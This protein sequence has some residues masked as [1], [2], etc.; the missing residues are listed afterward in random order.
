MTNKAT[1]SVHAGTRQDTVSGGVNTPLIASS[2]H[3]YL[4]Q[5]EVRYPRYFNTFNQQVVVE[6]LCALEQAEDGL[7]MSSGM[8]A[9]SLL[10]VGTLQHGDHAVFVEGIYGGTQDW[11]IGEL[12]A[13]GIEFDFVPLDSNAIDAACTDRTRLIYV[14]SPTNPLIDVLDLAA[15]AGIAQARGILSAIDNTFA[16]PILQNPI[17]LGIDC[18]IHSGTKYLGGHSD[19]C[20]GAILGSQELIRSLRPKAYR[21]G[22]SINAQ[23]AALLERSLKTL[24]LRVQRQS[25]NALH[26]AQA[27][28]TMD[29]VDQVYYPGLTHHPGHRIAAR[30]MSGFGGML[31]FR[32][33]PDIDP[34]ACLRRLEIIAPAVSLGGVETTICQPVQTSH[35]KISRQECERLGITPQLLRLSVGIE[36]AED[37][38]I[39]LRRAIRAQ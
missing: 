23:C 33:A 30:Q 26:I 15:V 2:A 31:S 4:N 37:L 5:P 8:A 25:D 28:D 1:L 36:A 13:R 17:A 29:G 3:D 35:A 10:L 7:L 11:A 16:S 38:A 20:C 14:E 18:V 9:I 19:L 12:A 27:L 39:D 6:K 34:E 22:G 21:Y 32:L 24:A